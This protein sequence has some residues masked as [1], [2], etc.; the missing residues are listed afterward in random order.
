MIKGVGEMV[1]ED[2]RR[3]HIDKNQAARLEF[4]QLTHPKNKGWMSLCPYFAVLRL[5]L[6]PNDHYTMDTGAD[7]TDFR[8]GQE[9]TRELG[10]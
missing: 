6:A 5:I 1:V 2:G 7:P 4:S 10:P 9:K 8:G 3:A